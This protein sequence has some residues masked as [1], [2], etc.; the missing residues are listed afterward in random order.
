[1]IIKK[2]FIA[3]ALLSL[4]S[5]LNAAS[6]DVSFKKEVTAHFEGQDEKFATEIDG[7]TITVKPTPGVDDAVVLECEVK[8]D[9]EIIISPTLVISKKDSK[10]A[11]VEIGHEKGNASHFVEFSLT[12]YK[13]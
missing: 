2:I 12:N 9:E 7:F 5:G 1:M 8:Q 11:S 6:F 4:A 3:I 13:E 10:A